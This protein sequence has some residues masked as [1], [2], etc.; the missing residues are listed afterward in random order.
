MSETEQG[1]EGNLA[2]IVESGSSNTCGYQV[3]IHNDG[4]ATEVIRG[5]MD[6]IVAR[7][8]FPPGTIDTKTL[9]SLLTE[10][11]D[12]STIPT[13]FCVKPVSFATTT[14]ISYAGKTSGD[15]QSIPQ[16]ASGGDQ[17]L[18]Q[19]S[20]DL[21]RFVQTTLSQLRTNDMRLHFDA[22]QLKPQAA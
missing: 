1:V 12:V 2:T 18:L 13:G 5:K 4:S 15:L 21:D 10:I 14:T 7:R 22:E 11:G 9:L 19:A 17:A 16:Y 20:K 8:K 3:V 6:A